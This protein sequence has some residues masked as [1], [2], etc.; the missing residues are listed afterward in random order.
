MVCE[1][2]LKV[3]IEIESAMQSISTASYFEAFEKLTSIMESICLNIE[4]IGLISTNEQIDHLM[5]LE[6]RI[7]FWNQL[8]NTFVLAVRSV[9]L[10]TNS[11]DESASEYEDINKNGFGIE[12]WAALR[13]NVI[14]CGD[15]LEL[16]G[17]VDYPVGFAESNIIEAIET[18]LTE[19]KEQ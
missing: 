8:N 18:R 12:D 17:L 7:D 5:P 1:D 14:A 15:I 6:T 3:Q 16:Y 2:L 4:S 19:L 9:A 11:S 13:D 10:L